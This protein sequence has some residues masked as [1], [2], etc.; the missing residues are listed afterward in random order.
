MLDG[1]ISHA[2]K[3]SKGRGVHVLVKVTQEAV[4]LPTGGRSVRKSREWK[5]GQMF[6]RETRNVW[7]KFLEVTR[8]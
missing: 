8:F 2:A 7:F 1:I 3:V 6:K 5:F 4:L